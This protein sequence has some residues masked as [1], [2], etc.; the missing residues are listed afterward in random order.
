MSWSLGIFLGILLFGVI[1]LFAKITIPKISTGGLK[2]PTS[3]NWQ[4]IFA[5]TG[6]VLVLAL[7]FAT[8][9]TLAFLGLVLWS[10]IFWGLLLA[11]LV[12]WGIYKKKKEWLNWIWVA[13][14]AL[15]IYSIFLAIFGPGPENVFVRIYKVEANGSRTLV[16]T[17][18]VPFEFNLESR[19]EFEAEGGKVIFDFPCYGDAAL[20]PGEKF[21]LPKGSVCK[22]RTKVRHC[23]WWDI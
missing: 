7:F 1:L 14:A 4:L 23:R 17:R 16:E 5:I 2:I 10:K 15:V 22:G 6:A 12:F 13:L 8:G 11:G 3:V 19:M 20:S 18:K 21:N 9:S